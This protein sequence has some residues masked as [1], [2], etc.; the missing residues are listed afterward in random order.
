[1]WF[2]YT[3]V[4][5]IQS[6]HHIS[7]LNIFF[8]NEVCSYLCVEKYSDTMHHSNPR[9]HAVG[10][11][12]TA[13]DS[14]FVASMFLKALSTLGFSTRLWWKMIVSSNDLP[15]LNKLIRQACCYLDLTVLYSPS[16]TFVGAAEASEETRNRWSYSCVDNEKNHCK[17]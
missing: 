3:C 13:E 15:Y 2:N 11:A 14:Y 7:V 6:N 1:M 10:S 17:W 12:P 8:F 4:L 5:R 9:R 16:P